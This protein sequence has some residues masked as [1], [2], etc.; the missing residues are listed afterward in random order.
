MRIRLPA[1]CAGL[2]LAL[3]APATASAAGFPAIQGPFPFQ[4]Q[5]GGFNENPVIGGSGYQRQSGPMSV[6]KSGNRFPA[7]LDAGTR[8]RVGVPANGA[9]F[10]WNEGDDRVDYWIPQGLTGSADAGPERAAAYPGALLASWYDDSG[11]RA[12]ISFVSGLR[13]DR[14]LSYRHVLLVQPDGRGSYTNVDTHAGGLAWF[15]NRLYVA[16]TDGI[17]VFDMRRIYRVKP[18]GG[19]LK[20]SGDYAYVMPQIGSYG[21]PG[22]RISFVAVDSAG[23]PALVAGEY[24]EGA[25]AGGR[26]ARFPLDGGT[27]DLVTN[28]GADRVGAL[29][30]F[31]SPRGSMQGAVTRGNRVWVSGSTGKDK[32][33][34]LVYGT[35]GRRRSKSLPWLVG[36]EDLMWSGGRLYSL[37]EYRWEKRRF[38]P[39]RRGR[40]VVSVPAP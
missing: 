28:L 19:R 15:R 16:D 1:L 37:S 33:G 3:L 34:A 22:L 27:G 29:G 18:G 21:S 14:R 9:G 36:A 35:V 20:K 38:L 23:S 26:I 7:G 25:G 24:K 40:V 12:R 2:V 17:R 30:A 4:L 5:K 31:G 10:R 11:N 39:D 32:R 6:F 13:D 8:K